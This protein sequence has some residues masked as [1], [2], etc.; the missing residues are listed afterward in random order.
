MAEEE[1][2]YVYTFEG[3]DEMEARLGSLESQ[4]DATGAAAADAGATMDSDLAGGAAT[5]SVAVTALAGAGSAKGLRGLSSIV[6]AFNPKLGKAVVALRG[7]TAVSMG[8]AAAIGPLVVV[9]GAVLLAT[10]LY[11]RELD[12][13]EESAARASAQASSMANAYDAFKSIVQSTETQAAI[14]SGTVTEAD[15]TLAKFTATVNSSADAMIREIHTSEISEVAKQQSI[16]SIREQAGATIR[17]KAAIIAAT[18]AQRTQTSVTVASNEVETESTRILKAKEEARALSVEAAGSLRDMMLD[19]ASDE[20]TALEASLVAYE[21]RHAMILQLESDS[22]LFYEGQ[23]A[24]EASLA[25]FMR[26][27]DAITETEEQERQERRRTNAEI[28]EDAL[29]SIARDTGEMI[30]REGG[31]AA[32]VQFRINQAADI[33]QATMA[34]ARAVTQVL[35]NIP[36]ALLVGAAGGVQ[37]AKIASTPPPAVQAHMGGQ[38]GSRDPLAPDERNSAGVRTLQQELTVLSSQ[39]VNALNASQTA[40]SGPSRFRAVIGRGHLDREIDRSLRGG[41]S[42]FSTSNKRQ[43]IAAVRASDREW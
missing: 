23:M 36:L 38:I 43:S 19:V 11:R 28:T 5:A 12:R 22:K 9:L 10:E 31:K 27:Q 35:P 34:T 6:G 41:L 37:I 3:L 29:V 7:L 21:D 26:E 24:R 13:M 16:W 4:F 42:R 33:A 17:Q 18:E 30:G 1:I 8:A 2:R 15:V 14:L 32:I 39:A 40:Q 20:Q 25:R